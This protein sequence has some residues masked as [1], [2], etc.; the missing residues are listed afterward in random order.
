MANSNWGTDPKTLRTTALALS[1]STAEY[2]S[3]VWGRSCHAYKLDPELNNACRIIT[4]QLRA[5][6]LP[7][8]YRTAGIAPPHIRR[9]THSQTQK[10]RQETDERHPL[11]NHSNPRGR[12]KSRESFITVESLHPDHSAYSRLDKW[13]EWDKTSNDAVQ[14]PNEQLPAGTDLKRKDWVALNRARAKVGNTTSNL[15]K[16]KLALDTHC[17]CGYPRQ[18]MDHILSECSL[19]PHCRDDNQTALDWLSHWHDKI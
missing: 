2:C 8:L 4:G 5:T 9:E 15:F 13:K 7:L 10:F 6:P 14:P 1:Y 17:P 3:P 12:L 19:G 11:Y 16:W 18:T